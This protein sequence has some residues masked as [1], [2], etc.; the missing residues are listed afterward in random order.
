V[1]VGFPSAYP[2]NEGRI[3]MRACARYPS[4]IE[5]EIT[6]EPSDEER[7][8]IAEAL[9]EERAGGQETTGFAWRRSA[10]D[11]DLAPDVNHAGDSFL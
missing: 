1:I 4:R 7:S 11:V 10:I 5:L 2:P 6:P 9:A 3:G 8:A